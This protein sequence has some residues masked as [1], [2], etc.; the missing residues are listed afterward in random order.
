MS[1]LCA[2]F[3]FHLLSYFIVSFFFLLPCNQ[4]EKH[5]DQN[6]PQKLPSLCALDEF[7]SLLIDCYQSMPSEIK[8]TISTASEKT[9]CHFTE[10][11]PALCGQTLHLKQRKQRFTEYVNIA[12][13]N[14]KLT[15]L[16]LCQNTLLVFANCDYQQSVGVNPLMLALQNAHFHMFLLDVAAY[17]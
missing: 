10:L 16:F 14:L 5:H 1:A 7:G 15:F 4:P 8:K 17:V 6:C 2:S 11:K 9:L 13:L 12:F 3:W